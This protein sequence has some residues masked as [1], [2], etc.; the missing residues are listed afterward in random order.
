[1]AR[2]QYKNFMG[3]LW[4]QK[5][6][7]IFTIGLNEDAL[8]DIESIASLDLPTEGELVEADAVLGSIE[9]QD[10]PLELFSPVSGTVSEVNSTVI[11]DPTLIQDDPYDSWLFKIESEDEMSED[12]DEDDEDEDDDDEDEDDEDEEAEEDEE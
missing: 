10:G 7:N 3:Y 4:V 1:M 11:E 5:E 9:T 6:D 2:E 8:D 12:D